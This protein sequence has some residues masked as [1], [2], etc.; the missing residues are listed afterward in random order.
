MDSLLQ[1]TNVYRLIN[2]EGD[3]LS[4]LVVDV[5]GDSAVIESSAA[6]VEIHRTAVEDAVRGALREGVNLVWRRSADKLRQEGY[7]PKDLGQTFAPQDPAPAIVAEHGLQFEV[8]LHSGQKTGYYC[9]QRDNRKLIA[10]LAKDADVLDCFCYTGGFGIHAG[11]NGARSVTLVDSSEPSLDAARRNAERNNVK[12]EICK[13]DVF[14]FL[15]GEPR[16]L[17]GTFYPCTHCFLSR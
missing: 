10:G 16:S 5:F 14:N 3:R 13:D 6:W 12:A 15:S 1:D 4:G 8:A 17:A 2:G 9:D 7:T 11:V